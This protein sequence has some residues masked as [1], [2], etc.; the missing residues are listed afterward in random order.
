M[1][2]DPRLDKDENYSSCTLGGVCGDAWAVPSDRH[3]PHDIFHLTA[4]SCQAD[5]SL[6]DTGCPAAG[7]RHDV[8]R[9][10]APS[11]P[12][13][14]RGGDG[15][16]G[17]PMELWLEGRQRPAAQLHRPD[18]QGDRDRQAAGSEVVPEPAGLLRIAA[19]WCH[20]R[21][22]RVVLAACQAASTA[23]GTWSG[24]PCLG[25]KAAAPAWWAACRVSSLSNTE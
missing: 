1:G 19:Q 15:L 2:L 23:A 17:A 24:G 7:R 12:A 9:V 18:C 6:G 10:V 11:H 13:G 14:Y 25:M 8:E 5:C 21:D 16:T 20:R 3:D 22:Q 4:T